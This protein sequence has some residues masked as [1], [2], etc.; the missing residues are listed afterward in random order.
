MSIGISND[1]VEKIAKALNEGLGSE[2]QPRTYNR[3]PT[4]ADGLFEI[5]KQLKRHADVSEKMV[6][7]VREINGLEEL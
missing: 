7:T 3:K 1:D 2:F 4:I 6:K 5:A